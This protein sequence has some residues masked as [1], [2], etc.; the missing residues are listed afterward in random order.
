MEKMQ[1]R[2]LR[3]IALASLTSLPFAAN[4]AQPSSALSYQYVDLTALPSAKLDSTL[5]DEN[6][7]GFLARGSLTVHQSIAVQVEAQVLNLDN[8][9]DTAKIQIGAAGHWAIRSNLDVVARGGIVHYKVDLGS[10]DDSKT[11]LYIGGRIRAIVAPQFE[12]EG[13]IEHITADPAR[14]GS[15]T[16]VVG[17]ARYH[18]TR[19]W[20]A[21]VLVNAGGNSDVF[22]LQARL[23][24]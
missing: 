17:E 20:S 2:T 6:G 15:D 11:G 10:I 22:G 14:I 12:V 23:S 5:V 16:F 19:E 18:F 4:A 8:G 3:L 9:V 24:F 13:G 7:S 1:K 21:G